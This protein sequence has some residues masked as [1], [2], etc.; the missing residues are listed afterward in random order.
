MRF[1]NRFEGLLSHL[2][3]GKFTVSHI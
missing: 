3:N 1:H 2:N